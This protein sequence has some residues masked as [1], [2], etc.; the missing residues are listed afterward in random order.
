MHRGEY[1]GGAVAEGGGGVP[2]VAGAQQEGGVG[3]SEG[4]VRLV[5]GGKGKTKGSEMLVDG[6][7]G[8]YFLFSLFSVPLSQ[9]MDWVGGSGMPPFASL[10][11]SLSLRGGA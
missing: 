7:G 3:K 10:S 5:G 8:R 1:A 4:L 6:T 9:V 2:G 11:G